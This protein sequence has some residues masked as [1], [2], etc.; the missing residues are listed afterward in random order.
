MA[1]STA[2]VTGIRPYYFTPIYA[3]L[4]VVLLLFSSYRHIATVFKW[5]TLVLFAYPAA[6]FLAQPNWASV[7]RATFVPHI[8]WS[9]TYLATFVA[10]FG[11]TISPY[12]FFWQANQA[13]E[14][15]RDK[16]RTT[17]TQ[18]KGA[19]D[20][21]MKS[22]RTDTIAG[23]LFSNLI[24]YFI[25]LTTAA[26]SNAHGQTEIA[27]AQQAAETLRPFAGNAAY[28]VF[29]LGI[30]GTGM[31]SV[32]VL[33]GSTA[34]AI[35]EGAG[36]RTSLE[37]KPRGAR[38]FYSVLGVAMLLGL[39]L[40]WF[41]FNAVGMLF[42]SAVVNGVLAPPLIALVILLNC[43]RKV[44][45]DRVCPPL[46]RILGWFTAALMTFAAIAMFATMHGN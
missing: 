39:A 22:A 21:E 11:T 25:I 5:M 20:L 26:T 14:E 19:T 30:I 12:L 6:A 8:E 44:M 3:A 38:R 17:L 27:T 13:V 28:L 18:R 40:N 1:A 10:I 42:C 36:W 29:T 32:P 15:D 46:L 31:L 4:I 37:H 24:M 41:G 35:A 2:L 33:A 16:G 34:Y 43:S 9:S 23:M 45:G 7:A